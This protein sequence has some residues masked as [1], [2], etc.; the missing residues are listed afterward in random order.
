M[1]ITAGFLAYFSTLQQSRTAQQPAQ[2]IWRDVVG[3][4][5][6]S[7]RLAPSAQ[8]RNITVS[9]TC[10]PAVGRVSLKLSSNI[11]NTVTLS[12]SE[13]SSCNSS[14][15]NLTLAISSENSLNATGTLQVVESDLYKTLSG[16]LTINVS[17]S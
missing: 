8:S 11:A 9:F 16:Q 4:P 7:V 5:I 1:V 12:T 15:N 17:G 13:F 10:N 6:T 14:I 3:D 2:V